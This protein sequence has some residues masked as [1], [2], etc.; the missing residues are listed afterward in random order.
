MFILD[1]EQ[2]SIHQVAPFIWKSVEHERAATTLRVLG[3]LVAYLPQMQRSYYSWAMAITYRPVQHLSIYQLSP[4]H[5]RITFFSRWEMGL[6]LGYW[7][8]GLR[9][10]QPLVWVR[11]LQMA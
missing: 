2:Q 6:I 10:G 11:R 4:P 9:L 8:L 5:L 7:L 1:E 3:R